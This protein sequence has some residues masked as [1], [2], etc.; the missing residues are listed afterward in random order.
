MAASAFITNALQGA[1]DAIILPAAVPDRGASTDGLGPTPRG[2]M[3]LSV[4]RFSL[5]PQISP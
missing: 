3:S 4:P 1:A 2:Q 5:G